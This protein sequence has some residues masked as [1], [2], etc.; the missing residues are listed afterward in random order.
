MVEVLIEFDYVA[1]EPDELTVKKGDIIKDCTPK[2]DGWYQGTLNGKKGVFPDNFG[3]VLPKDDVVLRNKKDSTRIRQ[4]RV[5]FSYD[6]DHEDE[7]NLKVGEVIDII[8]EEEEGWWRGL[9]NGKEGVFPSNFVEEILP[10]PGRP[11]ATVREDLLRLNEPVPALPAKPVKQQCEVIFS[12]KAQNEDELTLK[13]GDIVTVLSK[14]CAD[15]GWWKGEL[16]GKVG[17]FPDNFVAMLSS[18]DK[19]NSLKIGSKPHKDTSAMTKPSST[20]QRKSINEPKSKLPD[21]KVTPP[22]P[23]KKPSISLMKSPSNPSGGL[24]SKL[25]DKIVDAVDGATGSKPN[26]KENNNSDSSSNLN[27]L[28]AFDEVSRRPLLSDVRA[29]RARAPGRRPPKSGPTKDD[30]DLPQM[31]NGNVDYPKS[32]YSVKSEDSFRSEG[33]ASS[34]NLDTSSD[35]DGELKPKLREWEKSKVPWLEEMKL[36]QAKRTNLV[37]PPSEPPKSKPPQQP[38]ESENSKSTQNSPAEKE[39]NIDTMSKSMSD[40]KMETKPIPKLTKGDERAPPIKSKPVVTSLSSVSNRHSI[41]AMLPSRE[42]PSRTPPQL[43]PS[44]KPVKTVE[45]YENVSV[46]KSFSSSY[47]TTSV[48]SEKVSAET[49]STTESTSTVKLSD[50]LERLVKLEGIVS[51]QEITIEELRNKLQVESELRMML[52][53]KLAQN[54]VQV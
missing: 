34:E 23:G 19:K 51:R 45:Q 53:E 8:G 5:V 24:F 42:S 44:P 37:S 22:L 18:D 15:A 14:D 26:S 50:I 32:E 1:Q 49:K 7:L 31:A 16:N 3:K 21:S 25:K 10:P 20:A 27:D 4:C 38:T 43:K 54:N 11:K 35:L 48:S 41:G 12:Y 2:C 52:Q 9:L 13:E 46:H 28:N 29:N 33:S 47:T 30:D 39:V 40:I 36:N 6:Q 17:V